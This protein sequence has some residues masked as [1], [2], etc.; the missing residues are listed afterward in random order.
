MI[1]LDKLTDYYGKPETPNPAGFLAMYQNE[2]G[3]LADWVQEAAAMHVIRNQ[4]RWG[5]TW[6][7]IPEIAAAVKKV[8]ERGPAALPSIDDF[9]A[10][11]ADLRRQVREAESEHEIVKALSALE[12]YV[13]AKYCFPSR[14]TEL[15]KIGAARSKELRAKQARNP[16]ARAMDR[17]YATQG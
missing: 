15:E 6:P 5:R 1:M 12:P 16:G 3:D 10:W 8:R 14:M 2:F 7:T 4:A 9:E 13:E 11:F 17:V